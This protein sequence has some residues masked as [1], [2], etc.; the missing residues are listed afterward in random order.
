MGLIMA[1]VLGGALS[2]V[3]CGSDSGSSAG[4]GGSAGTGGSAGSGGGDGSTPTITMV[5]WEATADCED[6]VRS[7]FVVTVTATDPD[8]ALGDLTYSGSVSGCDGAID[9]AVSTIN[10]PNVF[11]YPGSVIVTDPDGNQSDTV[12]FDVGV[13]ETASCTTNPD[14]CTR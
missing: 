1:L 12:A 10:C 8:T 3:G 11:P 9:A 13:C 5:A 7:N 4:A 2:L 6:F 14:T